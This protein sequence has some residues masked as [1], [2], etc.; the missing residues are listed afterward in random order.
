MMTD[1]MVLGAMQKL[2]QNGKRMRIEGRITRLAEAPGKT[3][4]YT[5]LNRQLQKAGVNVDFTSDGSI[6]QQHET[7]RAVLDRLIA[8]KKL[9]PSH[10]VNHTFWVV[11]S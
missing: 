1:A 10:T 7:F 6:A 2:A 5:L 3:S 9:Y 11:M 8:T 4:V